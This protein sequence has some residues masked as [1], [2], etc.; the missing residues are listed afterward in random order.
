MAPSAPA[1]S[2]SYPFG[3]RAIRGARDGRRRMSLYAIVETGG[4][5][6]RL[7]GTH[8][9]GRAADGERRHARPGPR[10]AG[11]WRWRNPRR[12]ARS[13][14]SIVR[15]PEVVE[16]GRGRKIIVFRYKSKVRYRRKTRASSGADP[17]AHHRL[18]CSRRLGRTAR[19]WAGNGALTGRRAAS[20][21]TELASQVPPRRSRPK[22]RVDRVCIDRV[23]RPRLN[24][25]C[26]RR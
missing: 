5:Q 3:G 24:A 8:H 19:G 13:R 21:A 15:Q 10:A 4:K 2:A 7:P 25:R 22:S 26:S 12:R 9:R 23:P 16:H 20:A 1:A 17:T 14:R 6:Y 11:R 18:S